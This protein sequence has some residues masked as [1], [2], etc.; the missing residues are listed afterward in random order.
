VHVVH[1]DLT[2]LDCDVAVVPTDALLR[3]ES[4]W[5]E[6]VTQDEA[7]AALP[8]GWRA[9]GGRSAD[10]GRR[11]DDGPVRVLVQVAARGS[12]PVG[13]YV[14]GVREAL[15]RTQDSGCRPAARRG[16]PLVGLPLVGTGLGGG[17]GS[18]GDLIPPLLELLAEHVAA[19]DVDV[20]LVTFDRS[21]YAAVQ[22]ARSAGDGGALPAPLEEHAQRLAELAAGGELVP[23][24]GAGVSAA[25]GLPAWWELLERVADTGEVLRG[26]DPRELHGL[27]PLDAAELLKTALGDGAVEAVTHQLE[28]R[29]HALVHGLLASLRAPRAVTT[30]YDRLYERACERPLGGLAV[31]PWDALEPGRPWL[32]KVHGDVGHPDS[33]VLSR[34]DLL[35]YDLTRRPL[36]SLLQ[37]QMLTGHLLFVGSSMTDDA[38]IRLAWEVRELQ[39]AWGAP[40]RVVGTV[41]GLREEPLRARLWQDVLAFVPLAPGRAPGDD[42]PDAGTDGR[43]DPEGALPAFLDRLA[44]LASRERS[45]LLDP[46]YAGLV[47]E[48][49]RPLRAALDALGE[50]LDALAPDVD[51]ATSA[52]ATAA[53]QAF[54]R[55]RPSDGREASE[56]ER[57]DVGVRGAPLGEVREDQAH[58]RRELE[59][60]PGVAA[61]EH[62]AARQ[63]VEDEA[64][65]R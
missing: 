62:D 39:R 1:G 53:L 61:G 27:G 44:Q 19:V 51:P 3:V 28:A 64:P 15:R 29:R 56:R 5:H 58:E 57:R 17:A 38:V 20:A 47:P 25:A 33:I 7:R 18:R 63:R 41:L 40:P 4:S 37:G 30:N 45:Y 49:L 55:R 2:A 11:E 43:G 13:W 6:L 31:L 50:A 16:R 26:A 36:S 24:L 48:P 21:D 46:R 60:L 9:A 52:Q 12:E 34:G 32:A 23:F 8:N 54:G 22:A 59:P 10:I 35:G 42:V 65:V 14:D